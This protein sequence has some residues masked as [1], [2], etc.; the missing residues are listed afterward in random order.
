[1]KSTGG[2]VI[3]GAST[4]IGR[5]CALDLAERGF[6]VFAGVRQQAVGKQLEGL[7]NGSLQSVILDITDEEHIRR[8][9]QLV[10]DSLGGLAF[11]T[12]VWP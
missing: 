4:G 9:V 10:S 6:R 7:A 12:R 11:C 1:M 5:A 2:I 8:A 3:T